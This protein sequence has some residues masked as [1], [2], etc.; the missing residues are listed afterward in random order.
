MTGGGQQRRAA[1]VAS[2]V[3]AGVVVVAWAATTGPVAV[4]SPSGRTRSFAP[5]PTTTSASEPTMGG[6]SPQELARGIPPAHDLS[7]LG[8]LIAWALVLG[9]L[10]L[11]LWG[12]RY[13]VLH[14]WRRPPPPL[15]AD[16]EPLPEVRAAAALVEDAAQRMAALQEGDPRNGI[17]RCWMRLEESVADAGLPRKAHETSVEFT[18]RV[19]H[20]LDL[21]PHAIGELAGLYREARFSEHPL[22]EDARTAARDALT[23]LQDDLAAARSVR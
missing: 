10:A 9:V 17:V 15:T 3:C 11:A 8:D 18:V 16:A 7:W 13:V 6:T 14:R 21:D 4:M 19:L 23:R 1:L 20:V 12:L 2:A 22:T 5:A